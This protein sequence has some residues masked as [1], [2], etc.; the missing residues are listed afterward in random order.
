MPNIN[1]IDA[2][3]VIR[4]KFS[5]EMKIIMITNYSNIQLVQNALK[6][7]LDGFI[8]KPIEEEF[9]IEKMVNILGRNDLANKAMHGYKTKMIDLKSIEIPSMPEVMMK[10]ANFNIEDPDKGAIELEKLV[11]PDVG[12]STT[13][14]RIANSSYY[15]RSG[16]VTTLKKAI[17]M[18]GVKMVKNL[19][20]IEQNKEINK[21]LR[22]PILKKHI[23]R[24]PILASLIAFDIVGPVQKE[25][26]KE[27]IFLFTLM[28]KIG[29]NILALNFKENYIN[30][31]RLYDFGVK[32][33]YEL[34]QEEFNSTSIEIGSRVFKFWKLPE[35]FLQI[36]EN[37]NFAIDQII[38]V[39]DVDRIT[40][41]ADILS[42]Q[43]MELPVLDSEREMV[44]A[45]YRYYEASNELKAAFGEDYFEIIKDHPFFE[46][47][48]A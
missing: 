42:R 25:E 34:E 8:L 21:N 29:M 37:Q 48:L 16:S 17:K 23:R 27:K 4:Q 14:I 5:N 22:H 31:L 6:L 19:I 36:V 9:V 47:S 46:L 39:S 26:L 11:S 32:T 24:Q 43:M 33:I 7:K 12:I 40:R 44:E 15:G 13:I 18:L 10:V 3:R 2:A 35:L 28:R 20:I 1:G 41:L 45:I 38:E 30:I